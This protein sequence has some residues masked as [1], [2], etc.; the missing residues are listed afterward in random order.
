MELDSAT[1]VLSR[2]LQLWASWDRRPADAPGTMLHP[3]E[4][5][6]VLRSCCALVQKE[7]RLPVAGTGTV[8]H[9]PS[10]KGD[11]IFCCDST[12]QSRDNLMLLL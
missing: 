6:V 8:F 9:W 7:C 12:A 4:R 2:C 11:C 10:L 3:S 1:A 5:S